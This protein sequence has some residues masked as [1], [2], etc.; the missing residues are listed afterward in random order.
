[1]KSEELP[2][3]PAPV[4]VGT[5]RLHDAFVTQVDMPVAEAPGALLERE[6]ELAVLDEALAAVVRSKSGGLTLVAGEAGVGK[7]QL[8]RRFCEQ[9]AGL[10]VL[11]AACDALFTP[12]PL[13]P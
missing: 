2:I 6:S 12:R 10:R 9:A 5:R 1:V 4:A 3:F 11:W 7:T 8:L 13:G